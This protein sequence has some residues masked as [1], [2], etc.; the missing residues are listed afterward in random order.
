MVILMGIGLCLSCLDRGVSVSH[1]ILNLLHQ[2]L[3]QLPVGFNVRICC[4]LVDK[5]CPA[6]C[7]LMDCSPPGSSVHA[8]SQARIREWVAIFSSRGSSRL[9]DRTRVSGLTCTVGEFF[10]TEPP[11][12]PQVRIKRENPDKRLS[13]RSGPE[14]AQLVFAV[15]VYWAPVTCPSLFLSLELLGATWHLTLFSHSESSEHYLASQAHES[16][17]SGHLSFLL[18]LTQTLVHL[19]IGS[20]HALSRLS[21]WQH[22]R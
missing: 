19:L 20:G 5:S 3:H 22:A 12:K 16:Q 18:T 9:R 2:K 14:G 8:T 1:W 11:G 15:I 10:T 21:S 7:D 17:S 6:L 13:P 4:C